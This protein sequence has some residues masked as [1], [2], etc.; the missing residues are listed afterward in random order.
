MRAPAT[1]RLTVII[2]ALSLAA[3]A[4]TSTD[5][6]D[7]GAASTNPGSSA[8]VVVDPPDEPGPYGVG[9]L[10]TEVVDPARDN[11]TLP[12]DIWY[13][14]A[15]DATG[16][17]TRYV[18]AGDIGLDAELARDGVEA[19][20]GPFPLIVFSH[21]SGGIRS[22]S[23]FLTETLTSH[24]FVVASADHIGN[25]TLDSLTGSGVPQAQSAA[26][27]PADVVLV[28]DDALARNDDPS[29]VLAGTIDPERIGL[30]GHSFGGFTALAATTPVPD[31]AIEPRIDVI[32]PIAPASSPFSEEQLT[33]I[34]LPTL[35]VGGTEDTTTPID[36]E[37]T[38]PWEL[39]GG[40][41]VERVDL[42]GVGHMAFSEICAI[43][44][45]LTA[46][47]QADLIAYIEDFSDGACGPDAVP[48]E[49]V[50]RLTNRY[51]VAFF[52]RELA[53]ADGYDQFLESTEDA[54][55]SVR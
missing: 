43:S 30:T 50:H 6:T 35:L 21:G 3:A 23:V 8:P 19:A 38:H 26:D 31:G 54:T 36:P 4:C 15:P 45:E 37:I 55:Y 20:D 17:A 24:G 34:T 49:N 25:T 27:R 46:L 9:H 16:E 47:G 22:Q 12:V 39:L 11:R 44:D 32:V 7:D 18:L 51:V 52:L 41:V 40:D 28:I 5:S 53:G 48:I 14:T 33:A 2:A 1:V 29:S 42:E 10:V 13:P